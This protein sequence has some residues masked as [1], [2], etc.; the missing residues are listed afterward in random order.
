MK[1]QQY[2]ITFYVTIIATLRLH[3]YSQKEVNYAINQLPEDYGLEPVT[4][5]EVVC[6]LE[7]IMERRRL[8]NLKM[9]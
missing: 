4:A 5:K 6:D 3:G 9:N 2:D 8:L 7:H 1:K